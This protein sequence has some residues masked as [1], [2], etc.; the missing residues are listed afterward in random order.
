M[1]AAISLTLLSAQNPAHQPRGNQIGG[2]GQAAD[3]SSDYRSDVSGDHDAW[4]RDL[5]AWRA[6]RLTRMGYDDAEYRRPEFAWAQR[7]FISPQVMVEERTL[8]DPVTN[9]WTVDK[10]LDDLN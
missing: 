9:H 3:G 10:Y 6:E 1:V 5:K 7:N 4:M 8:F 2:P